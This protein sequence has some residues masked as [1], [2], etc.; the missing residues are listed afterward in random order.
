MQ[1]GRSKPEARVAKYN[2]GTR[3]VKCKV[4]V[5]TSKY[6]F[7]T[8]TGDYIFGARVGNYKL[9]VRAGKYIFGA[10]ARD[11]GQE[12]A[13]IARAKAKDREPGNTRTLF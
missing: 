1:I 7:G 9:V 8:R 4:L 3:A 5:R 11:R 2:L 10:R 13:R 12:P 6:I